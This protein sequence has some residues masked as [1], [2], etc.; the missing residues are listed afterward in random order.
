T[1]SRNSRPELIADDEQDALLP[2]RSLTGAWVPTN[3][4]RHTAPRLRW[5]CFW[6][7]EPI[8]PIDSVMPEKRTSPMSTIGAGCGNRVAGEGGGGDLLGGVIIRPP[9]TPRPWL[10][11]RLVRPL[12]SRPLSSVTCDFLT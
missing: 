7:C 1:R 5:F 3:G 8:G 2:S 11:S 6:F 10:A 9:Q 12:R 4:R